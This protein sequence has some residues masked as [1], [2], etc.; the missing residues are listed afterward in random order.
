MDED[1]LHLD[2]IMSFPR[3][4]LMVVCEDAMLEGLPLQ[5]TAA[6]QTIVPGYVQHISIHETEFLY[7]YEHDNVINHT[8]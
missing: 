4:G 2:C 5:H 3:D 8:R 6:T 1:I 7:E